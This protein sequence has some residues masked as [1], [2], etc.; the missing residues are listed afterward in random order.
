MIVLDPASCTAIDCL[1]EV[2]AE[3]GSTSGSLTPSLVTLDSNGDPLGVTLPGDSEY[4][5]V[6]PDPS[7]NDYF[8]SGSALA[9]TPEGPTAV[10]VLFGMAAGAGVFFRRGRPQPTAA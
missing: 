6:A 10:Y 2:E 7:G 8:A 4:A 3:L 9:Q 5:G 1:S